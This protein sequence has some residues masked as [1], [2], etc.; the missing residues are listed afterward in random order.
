MADHFLHTL[1]S[2]IR[3]VNDFQFGIEVRTTSCTEVSDSDGSL[4]DEPDHFFKAR[5]KLHHQAFIEL[6]R[7]KTIFT[8]LS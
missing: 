4:Q 1:L 6:G 8:L 7:S 2:Y 5:K 3:Q